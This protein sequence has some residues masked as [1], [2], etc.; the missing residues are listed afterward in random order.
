[1]NARERPY[2]HFRKALVRAV[3]CLLAS[4]VM[5]LAPLPVSSQKISGR[6]TGRIVY[7]S[8][9][10]GFPLEFTGSGPRLA[11]SFFNGDDRITSTAVQWLGDSLI[12]SFAHL[13]TEL[14][15][16]VSDGTLRGIYGSPTRGNHRPV[17]ARPQSA[18]KSANG[19]A[20]NIDGVWY[21]PH[22][23]NKGEH[24]WRFVIQQSGVRA[25]A[26]ILRIDGDA[27]AHVGEF[28]DGRFLLEHFDGARPSQLEVIPAADSVLVT[29]RGAR[30]RP[31][32]FTG[33]RPEVARARGLPEPADFALH[34][35][36]KDPD[37]PFHFSF[38]DL[39][40]NIVS[41]T[42][43]KFAGKVVIVNITGSWCPNCHDEAPFLSELHRKYRARGLE[44]VALDFEEPEQQPQLQRLRAFLERY[45][46]QYTYLLAGDP[47]ELT[48]KIPQAVNLNSWPTTF[49][50]GRA[51]T[52]RAVHAGFAA[53]A[54]GA[55]HEQ[56]KRKYVDT[57]E[58]L[59]REKR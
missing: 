58:E 4:I 38:P 25:T 59:L 45:R 37:E 43:P 55:Y 10:I 52:V 56:L 5:C 7:D 32:T 19:E 57:I 8:V 6:W 48:S 14:R 42:D 17:E 31:R 18:S 35:G 39:S 50:L 30:G 1:M 51:G 49:F 15:A 53:K 22:E 47:E 36:V 27:G 9:T 23:S 44:I 2:V 33:F 41:S 3:T 34:T 29:Q 11:A 26:T 12:V 28:A 20:P 40:G 21:L 13:A 46:I 24:A 16:V 54:T